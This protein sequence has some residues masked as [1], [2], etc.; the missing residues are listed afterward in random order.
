MDE[1]QMRWRKK[2]DVRRAPRAA[3]LTGMVTRTKEA[4]EAKEKARARA[5]AK[6]DIGAIA[7]STGVN[8]TPSQVT[9]SRVCT[10]V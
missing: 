7:G 5:R 6:P 2:K 10:H 9:F 3:S 4:L 8:R 1:W